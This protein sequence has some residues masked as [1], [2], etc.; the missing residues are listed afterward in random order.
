[1]KCAHNLHDY[2]VWCAKPRASATPSRR[3][4]P[5]HNQCDASFS[6]GVGIGR[7]FTVQETF[8]RAWRSFDSF[9]EESFRAWLYRIATNVCLNA[10]ESRKIE[11]LFAGAG[12]AGEK[13]AAGAASVHIWGML[14]RMSK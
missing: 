9:E 13:A 7:N 2:D 3:W 1:M 12:T 5:T 10:I 11:A 14:E 8:L 4:I 6:K